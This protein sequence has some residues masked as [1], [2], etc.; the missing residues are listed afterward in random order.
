MEFA[1][2]SQHV[3]RVTK[4][5]RSGW[6]GITQSVIYFLDDL[7]NMDLVKKGHKLVEVGGFFSQRPNQWPKLHTV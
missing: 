3:S 7:R 1:L 6:E 2:S 4:A 5:L